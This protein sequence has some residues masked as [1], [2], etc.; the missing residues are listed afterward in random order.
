AKEDFEKL[1]SYLKEKLGNGGGLEIFNRFTTSSIEPSKK[2]IDFTKNMIKGQKVFNLIDEQIAA[3]N[4]IIDRA[5][6]SSKLKKKAVIIVRGGPGTGKSVIGLNALAELLDKGLV[7]FHATGSSAFTTTLRKIVGA[8]PA[9]LFKYFN[10]F[11]HTQ[12]QQND[13]DVLICDEA[14]RIRK[15]SNSIYTKKEF[16]STLP[17]IDELIQ[18]AKVSIFFIDDYQIVRP[19]EIGS[20]Q[21]IKATAEKYNADIY[22][23]ELK[24][25]FRCNGSNGYLNWVDDVL[26]IRDTANKTLTKQEKME[27]KIFDSPK[28]L[29]NA[30]L[31]KN[32][33]KENSARLVAGF[34]WPW[35]NTK[36]DGTLVE[37]VVIG[38]FKMPWEAKNDSKF[39]VRD[40]PK[41][42]VWAYDPKGLGQIGTVYTVQGFEYEYIGIIFGNDIVYDPTQ[43]DWVGHPENS[44][45]SMVK[46]DKEKFLQNIK[47]VYRV[48]L[49]R[50]MKGCYI[51]FLDN[52]TEKYFRDKI[53]LK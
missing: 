24:T 16:R 29:Y 21:L 28:E 23:F 4:T 12:W 45:D 39:L 15:T 48:L 33:V 30:I 27:V 44:A 14:H 51:Y 5:K 32:K 49:T 34:C 40:I 47:N 25:Q 52:N 18:V 46:R 20:T 10:S 19:D 9:K 43:K 26:G 37:D 7:V 6:K 50:G 3:N 13:I 36:P 31:E 38:D 22:D 2:L 17:Q 42:S 8:R 35:S 1:G 41:A 53:V 11:Q